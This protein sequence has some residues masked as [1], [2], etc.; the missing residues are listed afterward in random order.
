VPSEERRADTAH[1]R[2]I[3]LPGAPTP[4]S[5]FGWNVREP[6]QFDTICFYDYSYD[7]G[8]AGIISRAWDFGDG[9]TSNDKEPEH[10]F[11]AD[12]VYA[13]VLT[14]HTRD[15]RSATSTAAL[16]VQTHDVSIAH[17]EIPSLCRAGRPVDIV[18]GVKSTVY[19]ETVEVR[20]FR[21]RPRESDLFEQVARAIDVVRAD[22]AGRPTLL[23]LPVTFSEEHAAAGSATLKT[24]VSIVG[25]R[26]ARPDDNTVLTTTAVTG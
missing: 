3:P 13:T 26:D 18:V 23:A 11:G 8:R 4:V 14:V 9:T 12:G 22:P 7:P 19:D 16:R 5:S 15:R 1:D 24:V 25:A 21:S 10:R 17:I 20:V 6:S 2:L